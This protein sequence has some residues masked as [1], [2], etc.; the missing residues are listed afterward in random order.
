VNITL[1]ADRPLNWLLS[2]RQIPH[3][4]VNH[5]TAE[6]RAYT[7]MQVRVL[8]HARLIEAMHLP[9]GT[10]GEVIAAV[11][12]TEGD[13]SKFRI[14]LDGSGRAMVKASEA[15]PD[16]E[17]DDCTWAAVVLGDLPAH[18]AAAMGLIS[19]KRTTAIAVLGAFS[20]GPVPFCEE[21]F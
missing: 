17:C 1:P 7:R 11:R 19:V 8:D 12:E 10:R 3:R 2:E 5:A 21:Y 20:A 9:E 18:A 15:L 13:V 14:A 16:V 6:I 4:L